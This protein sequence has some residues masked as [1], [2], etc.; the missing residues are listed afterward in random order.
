MAVYMKVKE[1]P[2]EKLTPNALLMRR[3]KETIIREIA[4]YL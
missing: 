1:M 3:V 4:K 2:E